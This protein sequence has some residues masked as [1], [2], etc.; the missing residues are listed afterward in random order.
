MKGNVHPETLI[1][2]LVKTGRPAE[3]WP[4]KE[5]KQSKSKNKKEKQSDQES[6]EE[7]NHGED[8]EKQAVKAEVHH[9]QDPSKH[10]EGGCASKNGEGTSKASG[11]VKEQ[12]PEAK[13]TV[14]SPAGSQPPVTEKNSSGCENEN[15]AEKSGGG[16]GGGGGGSGGSGSGGKKKKK[17][18][19][20]VSVKIDEGVEHPGD[21]PPSTG[22]PIHAQAQ[23]HAQAPHGH[24]QNPY[25]ANHS[26]PPQHVYHQSSPQHYY[27]QPQHYY[28]QPQ[29][30]YATS[31]S[32]AHPNSSHGTS[33]YASPT[34]PN[35]QVYMH[36][37]EYETNHPPPSDYYYG[38]YQPHPSD[39]F[40]L[41]SDENPNGCSIM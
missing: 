15:G 21:A 30:V 18:G 41:F 38:S 37:T 34:P 22:S 35:L 40:E 1:R 7:S 36:E 23:A 20:K 5:K 28:S 12:K 27:S 2:K 26:S 16:G 10:S 25:P 33:Y 31:Y 11:Q 19:H 3:L 17:K 4:E 39:S 24:G 32:M 14:T 6:S 29:P 8:K 13:Q 9:V